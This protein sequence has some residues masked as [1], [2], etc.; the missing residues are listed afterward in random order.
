MS[1]CIALMLVTS[2]HMNSE[3]CFEENHFS[4]NDGLW[5]VEL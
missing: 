1:V 5:T 3:K 4:V 2:K